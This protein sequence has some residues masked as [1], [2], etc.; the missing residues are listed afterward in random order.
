ME[1]IIKHLYNVQFEATARGHSVW[2]DQPLE[3]GG[4]D[5]GMTP[6][7]L[8][9]AALGTCAGYYAAKYLQSRQLPCTD[10][11]VRVKATKSAEPARLSSFQVDVITP[12]LD[13]RHEQGVLRAVKSCLIHNTL[14]SMPPIEVTVASVNA[15]EL[16]PVA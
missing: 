8:L 1:V 13:P 11:Q 9:L 12:P 5:T 10:L 7:E 4:G 14:L 6:P 15:V 16:A 2:C 3:Q